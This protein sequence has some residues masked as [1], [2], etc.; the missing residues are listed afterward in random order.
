MDELLKAIQFAN[1]KHDGQV[2]RGTNLPYIS[3]P[4][5]V[6]YL[7][8]AYKGRSKKLKELLIAAVLHDCLEDT[9]T[10]FEELV[11][12]F[13]PLVASLVLELTNDK[14]Q[15]QKMGKL[16]YQTKKLLGMSS[17][18]LV[19]KLADRL[20]NISD[21]PLPKML[22]NTITLMARLREG[23]KLSRSQVALVEAIEALCQEKKSAA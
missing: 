18:A 14:E 6:S 13:G 8:A 5:A 2:R 1:E 7:V 19:I 12:Q 11:A 3:H 9:D 10:R 21:Q 15:V 17:Y 20:H 22:D 16:E 4:V 23:R